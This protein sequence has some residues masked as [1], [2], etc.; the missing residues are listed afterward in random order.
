MALVHAGIGVSIVPESAR[1]FNFSDVVLRP[2]DNPQPK[3]LELFMVW[4][5]DNLNH[6]VPRAVELA[7]KIAAASEE[8]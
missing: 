4:R 1:L 5:G 8:K 3:R 7:R 6:L 2:I